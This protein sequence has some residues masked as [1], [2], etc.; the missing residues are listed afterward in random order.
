MSC[1]YQSAFTIKTDALPADLYKQ[2][3]IS[4]LSSS[5][6]QVPSRIEKVKQQNYVQV[7][8][9]KKLEQLKRTVQRQAVDNNYMIDEKT[10]E[11]IYK[12]LNQS[13]SVE[14]DLGNTEVKPIST[15]AEDFD[16]VS[17]KKS[18][19]QG[20]VAVTASLRFMNLL[21]D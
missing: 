16:F 2:R 12:E 7:Q 4:S 19:A 8:S 17:A 10:K 13:M 21:R 18:N 9:L 15:S 14:A 20:G 5:L 11:N 1:E 6:R 3:K